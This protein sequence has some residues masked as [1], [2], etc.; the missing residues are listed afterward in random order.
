MILTHAD[1]I[2]IS[3]DLSTLGSAFA[4]AQNLFLAGIVCFSALVLF[5]LLT[6]L[7]ARRWDQ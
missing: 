7:S 2:V 5:S 1:T 6:W 4:R 3:S